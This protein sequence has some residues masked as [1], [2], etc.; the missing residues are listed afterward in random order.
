[1]RLA[2]KLD[3]KRLMDDNLEEMWKK[4]VLAKINI[5]SQYLPKGTEQTTRIPQS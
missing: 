5:L 3:W 2:E 4:L 1:M